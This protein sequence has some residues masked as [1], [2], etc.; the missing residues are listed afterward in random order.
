MWFFQV[1]KPEGDSQYLESVNEDSCNWMMFV[2]PAAS[3]SEQNLVAYQHG[4]EIFFTA[5]RGIEP[6]TELKVK[7]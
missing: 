6:K 5:T 4:T 2:R 3:F 1:D 7:D